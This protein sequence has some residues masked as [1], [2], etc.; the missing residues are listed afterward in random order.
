MM[1][2]E[3]KESHGFNRGSMSIETCINTGFM[4]VSIINNLILNIIGDHKIQ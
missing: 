1:L 3:S 2:P 4:Q